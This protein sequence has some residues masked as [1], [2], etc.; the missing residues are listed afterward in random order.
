MNDNLSEQQFSK[1]SSFMRPKGAKGEDLYPQPEPD[2]DSMPYHRVST[3]EDV[4][5]ALRQKTAFRYDEEKG[6]V[7]AKIHEWHL[8]RNEDTVKIPAGYELPE[9][10]DPL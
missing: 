8:D 7:R 6:F 1:P 5:S 3:R 9:G 2:Y 10:Y 4:V